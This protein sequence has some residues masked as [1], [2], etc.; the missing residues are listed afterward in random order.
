M[1]T[2]VEEENKS[3]QQPET[4]NEVEKPLL[5]SEHASVQDQ[6]PL[7]VKIDQPTNDS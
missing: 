6:S 5:K 4:K 1:P 7:Q 2:Q 3:Q